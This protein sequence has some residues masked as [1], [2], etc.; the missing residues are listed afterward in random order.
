MKTFWLPFLLFFCAFIQAQN[1]E[2]WLLDVQTQKKTVVKDSAAAV[3]FLDSL[4]QNNFYFT[5]IVEV[6]NSSNR[7]EIFFDKGKN[8]N[9]AFVSV[10]PE[11]QTDLK[12]K[13]EFFTK[14]LDSLKRTISENYRLKGYIF[15]RVQSKFLGIKN[16]FPAV[17]L[18]VLKNAQRKIDK[19]VLKG[20]EKVPARFYKNLEK[21]FSGKVYDEEILS[22][23]NNSMQ[24]HQFFTL[25]KPPQTLF[26]K[27]STQVY[28]FLQKKKS[29][30]FDGVLGFG[31]DKS[32]KFT[33]NGSLN[34]NLRNIFNAFETVNIFWQRNPD[35]GQTFDLQTDIPYLLKSN[36]GA[37]FKVNI[38][39]QDSTYANV[40][41]TP[42]F[43][44][45]FSR[46]QKI[47]VRGT[48]ETSTVIDST[49]VQGKDFDKKGLGVWYQFQEPTEIDL[50]LYKSRVRLEA[51]Y[52]SANYAAE[53]LTGTQT[54]FLLSVER[55]FHLKGNHYLNL[56]AETAFLTSKN[57]FAVNELLR[58]GGWNSF[59]GFN[60][61]SFFADL[62][63]YGTA[64]YRHLVG[65]QAFFDVFG[66]YG[67]FQNKNLSLKPKIYSF[68]LGFNFFLPIGLMSFQISNGN[69]FGNAIQLGDTKI[70]WGI[71]SRF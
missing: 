7:T 47:G 13:N 43:Y 35:K 3:N 58:F 34:L 29:N 36:I 71:L 66:Q 70:H 8:Y 56:N 68:G 57:D 20:Y 28:L 64:E 14:N 37:D 5:K 11:I 27:D 18:S 12:F 50:F 38:F 40:K 6:K 22:D 10:S 32:E 65:N 19:I 52:V 9:E 60:E 21:D 53:K 67:G 31:N 26:T 4:A 54:N 2:F 55:N 49:Y 15:N 59:R 23:L 61:L 25:E 63:Y 41:L 24:N 39:R 45:N 42:A 62:Y 51:D 17:E 48:F 16:E 44:L 33:F 69:E 46:N 1:K 30:T